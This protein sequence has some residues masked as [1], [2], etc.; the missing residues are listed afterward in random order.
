MHGNALSEDKLFSEIPTPHFFCM[1]T[2]LL[3][4][5]SDSTIHLSNSHI[6]FISFAKVLK[7]SEKC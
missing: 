2:C 7:Y 4:F 6:S 3:M 5:P 1:L